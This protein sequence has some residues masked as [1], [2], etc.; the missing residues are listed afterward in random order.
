MKKILVALVGI[1]LMA[2]TAQALNNDQLRQHLKLFSEVL[3]YINVNYVEEPDSSELIHGAV[4][5]MLGELD[6]HSAFM[7]PDTYKSFRTE[8]KGEFGGL[9][10]QISIRDKVLTIIAPIEDTP[11]WD[12]GL[13]SGD[14][15][16]RIEDESTEGWSTLDAV[17]VLRGKPGTEVTITIWREGLSAPREV[18]IVRDIIAIESVKSHQYDDLGYLR[19]TSFRENSTEELLEHMQDLESQDVRGFILDL[20]NNPGGLLPQATG[21]ASIFLPARELVVYTQGRTME[22]QDYHT[23]E[24]P[25]GHR[26]TPLVVLVN[27]GSASASEI[28][29]AAIQDYG[30]GLVL[31]TQTFGKASVQS[32]IPLSDGSG[33]RLTTAR[34]YSPK[35]RSIQGVGIEPDIE[36]PQGRIV[37]D[38]NGADLMKEADLPGHLIGEMEG[39]DSGSDTSEDDISDTATELGDDLQLQRAVDVLKT[40]LLLRDAA[41]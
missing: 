34:Y 1:G 13:K 29:A 24:I 23:V 38:D 19:L 26:E 17:K 41:A 11:A 37:R 2:F 20:R 7:P 27:G 12:A 14:K 25:G 30:R 21:V 9:G 8:T 35:G 6:P 10:I 33:M 22:R 40:M 36:V 4:R 32:V 18:T 16:I 31:G 39:V 5:G 3:S 28:V 15:I